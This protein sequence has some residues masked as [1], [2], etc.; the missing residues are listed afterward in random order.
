[1]LKTKRRQRQNES[2]TQDAG[3]LTTV[4]PESGKWT[5]QDGPAEERGWAEAMRVREGDPEMH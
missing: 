4:R 1:M 2:G 3:R 5:G